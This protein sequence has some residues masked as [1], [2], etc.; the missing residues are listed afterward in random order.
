VFSTFEAIIIAA[1]FSLI[2]AIIGAATSA[3]FSGS[4]R[5]NSN[6]GEELATTKKEL[7]QYQKQ[8]EDHFVE[9]A[10]LVDTLTKNYRAVHNHLA[11]GASELLNEEVIEQPIKKIQ[12]PESEGEIIEADQPSRFAPLDYA[13]KSPNTRSGVLDEGFGLQKAVEEK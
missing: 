8:V 10:K 7:D 13:P 9:T 11:Q 2:G 1:L 5:A 12:G 3:R 6:L 4:S